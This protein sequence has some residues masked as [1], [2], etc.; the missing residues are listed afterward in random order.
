M[1]TYKI[2][3]KGWRV[4]LKKASDLR[5]LF[6]KGREAAA[7]GVVPEAWW[8]EYE[9]QVSSAQAKSAE[10]TIIAQS[11]GIEQRK[12]GDWVIPAGYMAVH[13]GKNAEEFFPGFFRSPDGISFRNG[14]CFAVMV[15]HDGYGKKEEIVGITSLPNEQKQSDESESDYTEETF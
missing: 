11:I 6:N 15:D 9:A 1:K 7:M 3:G 13:P 10:E 5:K 12:A 4:I 14:K 8:A 2:T